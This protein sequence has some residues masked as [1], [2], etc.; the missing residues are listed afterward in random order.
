M[1]YRCDVCLYSHPHVIHNPAGGECGGVEGGVY[2]HG[3]HSPPVARSLDWECGN[4][5]EAAAPFKTQQDTHTRSADPVPPNPSSAKQREIV[6][7]W[8]APPLKCC[9]ELLLLWWIFFF[10]SSQTHCHAHR[11]ARAQWQ[12][13]NLTWLW[14]MLPMWGMRELPS[15]HPLKSALSIYVTLLA[16]CRRHC[17]HWSASVKIDSIIVV[18]TEENNRRLIFWGSSQFS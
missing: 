2:A 3:D 12:R 5:W 1:I 8:G 11:R 16:H 13:C 6:L 18:L 10:A 15:G 7:H 17:T 9:D 14:G 4:G